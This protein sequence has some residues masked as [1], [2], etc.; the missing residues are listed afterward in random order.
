MSDTIEVTNWTN[1]FKSFSEK[2]I[3]RS[4]PDEIIYFGP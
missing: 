1:Y 3:A 4:E 2:N